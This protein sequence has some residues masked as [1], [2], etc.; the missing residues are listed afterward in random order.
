MYKGDL[1]DIRHRFKIE[2]R[3]GLRQS[4]IVFALCEAGIPFIEFVEIETEDEADY[5]AEYLE[6]RW[7]VPTDLDDEMIELA[8]ELYKE[9]VN[10]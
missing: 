4:K 2:T 9:S 7:I 5:I 3:N 8:R 10:V 1:Y 6:G